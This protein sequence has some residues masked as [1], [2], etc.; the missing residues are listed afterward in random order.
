MAC[1]SVTM[2]PFR[3]SSPV[4]WPVIRRVKPPLPSA[5]TRTKDGVLSR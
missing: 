3:S 1:I 4:I 2:R 5:L